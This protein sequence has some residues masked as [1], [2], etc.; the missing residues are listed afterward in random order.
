MSSQSPS[1]TCRALSEPLAIGRPWG[2]Q[3]LRLGR[4]FGSRAG[5]QGKVSSRGRKGAERKCRD[6]RAQEGTSRVGKNNSQPWFVCSELGGMAKGSSHT[7]GINDTTAPCLQPIEAFLQGSEGNLLLLGEMEAF[8][9]NISL[10]ILLAGKELSWNCSSWVWSSRNALQGAEAAAPKGCRINHR[11]VLARWN[12]L[13][14]ALMALEFSC[15]CSSGASAPSCAASRA[16]GEQ[17]A[18]FVHPGPAQLLLQGSNTTGGS[19]QPAP[20]W[21]FFW[22]K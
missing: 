18:L 7:Q 21:D 10:L 11:Q 22:G 14:G 9:F 16:L 19:Q 12:L 13:P 6:K 1:G 5:L 4:F 8:P 2:Q 3:F 15:L 17:K 20:E